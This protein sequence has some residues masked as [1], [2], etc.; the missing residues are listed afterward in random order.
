MLLVTKM[1]NGHFCRL[2]GGQAP[3][4]QA[5]QV[6]WRLLVVVKAVLQEQRIEVGANDQDDRRCGLVQGGFAFEVTGLTAFLEDILKHLL[7]ALFVVHHRLPVLCS[8]GG[9]NLEK[10]S[11]LKKKL[12]TRFNQGFE[13]PSQ[14]FRGAIGSI[15]GRTARGFDLTQAV[16]ADH[17]ANGLLGFKEL[18]DVGL[19]EPNRFGEIGDGRLLVTVATE[20]FRGC[21]DDLAT[22]LVVGRASGWRR[23]GACLFHGCELTPVPEIGQLVTIM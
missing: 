8:C 13:H 15:N 23:V 2:S 16:R 1:V 21:C 7:D 19:G 10:L 11:V 12:K 18:V 3:E 20:V 5:R 9:G 4:Y 6:R 17:L 14:L 22:H